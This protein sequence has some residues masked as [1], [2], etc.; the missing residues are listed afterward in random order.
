MDILSIYRSLGPVDLRNVR[1]DRLLA[2]VVAAPLL[3]ALL[4][5]F[6]VPALAELLRGRLGFD[7]A[8]YHGLLMSLF[9][10]TAPT[11][12]GMLAGFLLIDERD[13][14][15]LTAMLVTPMPLSGYLL[16][17]VTAPIAL[18]FVFTVACYPV[19]GLAPVPALDLL[20]I[21]LLA[22][23]NGPVTALFLAVFAENKVAG[24]ALVKVLNTINILPVAAFFLPPAW[25]LAAGIVPAFWPM[26][27]LWLAVAGEGYTLYAA[28]GLAV[29][30]MALALLLQRFE[31]RMRR[32]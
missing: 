22:S 24:F 17:R 20:A 28:A 1:R 21:A 10:L 5:R 25:Q 11:M 30:A 14:R 32:I 31:V 15:T 29:N 18:G 26:K 9:V 6:G 12:I 7:L 3:V 8:P 16:Y 23:L 13:D 4:Y 27:M 19:A 2:W